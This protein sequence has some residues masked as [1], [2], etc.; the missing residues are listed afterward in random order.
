[1]DQYI[2][3]EGREERKSKVVQGRAEFWT[4][5]ALPNFRGAGSPKSCTQIIMP[6]SWHVTW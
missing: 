6:A 5:F 4:V 2:D 1:M 3:K